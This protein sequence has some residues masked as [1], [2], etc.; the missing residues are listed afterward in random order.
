LKRAEII[1]SVVN[2]S[3]PRNTYNNASNVMFSSFISPGQLGGV[4]ADR[5]QQNFIGRQMK[6][7]NKNLII[8]SPFF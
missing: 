7:T 1:C 2:I 6:E 5:E 3:H 8:F 4:V